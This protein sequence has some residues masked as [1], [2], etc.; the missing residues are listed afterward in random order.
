MVNAGVETKSVPN[1]KEQCFQGRILIPKDVLPSCFK[2]M[3]EPDLEPNLNLVDIICPNAELES[4]RCRLEE[5]M[6]V[7]SDVYDRLLAQDFLSVF[8]GT[9]S[10]SQALHVAWAD[11]SLQVGLNDLVEAASANHPSFC[12]DLTKSLHE[13]PP[14]ILL[15]TW[16]Y[17]PERE[18]LVA[19]VRKR[20]ALVAEISR[21]LMP[22]SNPSSLLLDDYFW[23]MSMQLQC[24][25][26]CVSNFAQMLALLPVGTFFTP[27]KG[28]DDW[29]GEQFTLPSFTQLAARRQFAQ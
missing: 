8:Q 11:A 26:S 20:L 4:L 1:Q 22:L 19:Y 15:P 21:R 12:L 5:L 13:V 18:L 25:V 16:R 14:G 28:P 2:W 3:L 23:E 27:P 17:G 10:L 7:W 6:R 24:L 29:Y 9:I